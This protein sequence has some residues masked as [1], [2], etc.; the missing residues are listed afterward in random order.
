MRNRHPFLAQA[1]VS[2]GAN[3]RRPGAIETAAFA[4]TYESGGGLESGVARLL[5]GGGGGANASLVFARGAGARNRASTARTEMLDV[6]CGDTFDEQ[7]RCRGLVAEGAARA[8]VC[9]GMNASTRVA[10][11]GQ[12]RGT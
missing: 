9:A 7:T 2:Y 5:V 4:E 10:N 1:L 3:P 11:Q 8:F 6:V 12:K